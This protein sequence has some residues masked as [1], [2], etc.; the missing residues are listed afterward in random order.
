MDQRFVQA[1]VRDRAAWTSP[2]GLCSFHHLCFADPMPSGGGK[3]DG[4]PRGGKADGG[5]GG[6]IGGGGSDCRLKLGSR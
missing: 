6:R 3:A 2:P 5:G 1:L 4:G